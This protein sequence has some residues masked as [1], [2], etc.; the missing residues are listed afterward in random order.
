MALYYVAI[1][2]VFVNK[3]R[4]FGSGHVSLKSYLSAAA[5]AMLVG[6]VLSLI[7][8]VV[9]AADSNFWWGEA[10]KL[11]F[12]NRLRVC[13][14]MSKQTDRFGVPAGFPA[15]AEAVAQVC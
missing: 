3:S 15:S 7:V 6:G 8:A 1:Y 11:E 9:W 13:K 2:F 4:D 5:V 14:D 12:R 10:T